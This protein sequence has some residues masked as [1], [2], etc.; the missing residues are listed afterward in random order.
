M[1][2]QNK[3][4]SSAFSRAAKGV[5]LITAL[6]ATG[7]EKPTY[8]DIANAYRNQPMA[9][10]V[11]KANPAYAALLAEPSV[12][13]SGE[14]PKDTALEALLN[15]KDDI[16]P[17]LFPAGQEGGTIVIPEKDE[18]N[19]SG[20]RSNIYFKG[21]AG[22][23][24][25]FASGKDKFT[26][27]I[28]GIVDLGSINLFAQGTTF[29]LNEDMDNDITAKGT[30]VR[31]EAGAD[32][33][34]DAFKG[35]KLLLR[36]AV[37]GETRD[38]EFKDGSGNKLKM[39]NRSLG[40]TGEVAVG[41]TEL[42]DEDYF[43]VTKNFNHARARVSTR[44]GN[45]T[46]DIEGD[47]EATNVDAEAHLKL[48]KNLALHGGASY[49]TEDMAGL[50][51]RI[52]AAELGLGYH[53]DWGY[54]RGAALAQLR[55]ESEEKCFGGKL[56]AGIR[57]LSGKNYALDITGEA[58][59]LRVNADEHGTGGDETEY[60]GSIGVNVYGTTK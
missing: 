11:E 10:L 16:L 17:D 58:G 54:L 1:D 31:A 55:K 50:R 51:Q 56:E 19:S 32:F 46:G 2:N 47:H 36:T 22:A 52:V 48:G 20:S 35:G 5:A 40:F 30:G 33:Y 59:A 26:G 8:A 7:K 42:Q 24:A 44:K 25:Y 15:A 3:S 49:F 6:F 60:F 12:E 45:A 34:F 43:G 21:I 4:H 27:K 23:E 13:V 39:G 37:N 29:L 38:Y 9:V 18:P 41:E 14:P 28:K 57:V 53:A